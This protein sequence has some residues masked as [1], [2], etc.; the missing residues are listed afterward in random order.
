MS[1][2]WVMVSQLDKCNVKKRKWRENKL[3][4][5]QTVAGDLVES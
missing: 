3:H 2:E 4:T 1:S 5:T